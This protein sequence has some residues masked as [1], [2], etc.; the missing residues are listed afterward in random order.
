MPGRDRSTFRR[1]C[2]EANVRA[3]HHRSNGITDWNDLPK[4]LHAVRANSAVAWW[5]WYQLLL[6]WFFPDRAAG[7]RLQKI[8][9]SED[10]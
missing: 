1:C 8:F 5:Y 4:G 9:K 3:Y 7:W 10:L 6:R 2:V